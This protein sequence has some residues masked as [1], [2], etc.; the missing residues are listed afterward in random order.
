MT[1]PR[2]IYNRT[3]SYVC[4]CLC[5]SQSS[6]VGTDS[7]TAQGG[8]SVSPLGRGDGISG[9]RGKGIPRILKAGHAIKMGAVVRNY[10]HIL[11]KFY[12]L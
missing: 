6:D 7:Q 10:V 12:G 8:A 1:I 4:V 9:G 11:A 2:N 3:F 5:P